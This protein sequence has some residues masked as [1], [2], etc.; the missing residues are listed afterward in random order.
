MINTRIQAL[1]AVAVLAV[2]LNHFG[3]FGNK[4]GFF[5]VD[6]FFVISGFVIA[7]TLKKTN[8]LKTFYTKRIN[9]ILPGALVTLL[10]TLLFWQIFLGTNS[11]VDI[12][13]SLPS[14]S[15]LLANK[16]F[17]TN[18]TDYFQL[19]SGTS[20]YL[21]FWSLAVEEQFY[22]LLP[23]LFLFFFRKREKALKLAL[24][25]L[26]LLSLIYFLSLSKTNPTLAFYS[27]FS[28]AWELLTGVLIAITSLNKNESVKNKIFLKFCWF[29]SLVAFISLTFTL[30]DTSPLHL[31]VVVLLSAI[32]VLL[33]NLLESLKGFLSKVMIFTGNISYSL[34]LVH[35]PIY[36]FYL[37]YTGKE[38]TLT[39]GLLLLMVTFVVAT[40]LFKLIESPS[41]NKL[42]SLANSS[43]SIG[44][45]LLSICTAFALNQFYPH[46]G[47]IDQRGL[48]RDI[49]L[50]ATLNK[51]L[52]QSLAEG[53]SPSP[54]TPDLSN[55]RA[56]LDLVDGVGQCVPGSTICTKEF[57]S[58]DRSVVLFGD[59]HATMWWSSLYTASRKL[60]FNAILFSKG[61][62]PPAIIEY[63]QWSNNP[64]P[65]EKYNECVK[66]F[67]ESI[68]SINEIKPEILIVTGSGTTSQ[69]AENLDKTYLDF[70][71]LKSRKIL[72]AD[73]PYPIVNILDCYSR[74]SAT[75]IKCANKQSQAVI[76]KQ[77]ELEKL[78][79]KNTAWE[80]YEPDTLFCFKGL[81]PAVVNGLYVYRDQWHVT[82][83]YGKLIA[84]DFARLLRL[85]RKQSK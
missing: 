75:P 80:Y 83:L 44:I 55:L 70:K 40:L 65:I 84:D 17:Y 54:I 72:L 23:V 46:G 56:Q 82:R 42:N 73:F 85:E 16:Y 69:W 20:P 59:S 29:I 48:K 68:N 38:L 19:G 5:G 14:I 57:S 66:W 78:S 76:S 62:C 22:L 24:Y 10:V 51:V 41:R 58:A 43:L 18:Y 77:R 9:R 36:I 8:S 13:K 3:V 26:F 34:Y 12:V 81:C 52:S 47:K 71:N 25:A 2:I 31:T 21:H 1:R 64:P 11:A 32:L 27:P 79:I 4:S 15:Y 30:K 61:G 28:R 7:T 67:N 49:T 35:F 53:Y 6:L 37:R 63:K 50:S 60:G 33:S 39:I 45:L 74:S